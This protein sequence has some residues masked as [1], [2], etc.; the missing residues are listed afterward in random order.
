MPHSAATVLTIAI[1]TNGRPSCLSKCILSIKQKTS[2]SYTILVVDSTPI[3]TLDAVRKAYD[4]IY[5]AH[6]DIEVIKFP[7][8][9]SPAAARKILAE[10]AETPYLLFLDDDL[11]IKNNSIELMYDAAIN[12]PYQIIS[13][14]WE[15]KTGTRAAGFNYNIGSHN[16]SRFVLKSPVQW[17]EM[18]EDTIVRFHDVQASLFAK[19]ELFQRFPFDDRYD[20]YFDLFDFF[21]QCYQSDISIGVHGGAR[22]LHNPMKYRSVS[23]RQTQDYNADKNRFHEKWGYEPVLSRASGTNLRNYIVRGIYSFMRPR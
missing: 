5:S 11:E 6:S 8:T 10:K 22:F 9:V 7:H 20:F 21:F 13:G 14:I 1:P 4:E 12:T 23:A 15:E 19:T 18:P 16:N 2:L 3:D 17:D